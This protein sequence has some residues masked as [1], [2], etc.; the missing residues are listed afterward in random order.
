MADGDFSVYA[1][2]QAD[3]ANFEKGMKNAQTSANNLS[4]TFKNLQGIITKALSF[5]GVA[6]GTKAIIDFG[7]SAV[8][9]GNQA[10][11]Q[12][13][14]LD[15]TVKMT[16]ADAWTTTEDLEKMAKEL[17]ATTNY[18][19][20]EV[21]KMQSVLLGFTNITEGAFE[22]ASNA[23]LDMATVMGMDLTSAVQTV[24][25]ALDDPVTGLDSLRRQGFKFTDEQK[26]ELAQLVQNGKQL[27]AQKIILDTLA[28]SYGGASKAGQ[29]SFA[30]QRHAIENLKDTLGT[31]LIPIVKEFSENNVVMLN[32]LTSL[33]EKTDFTRIFA[34]VKA[35]ASTIKPIFENIS[36]YFKELGEGIKS[37]FSVDSL[38]PFISVIDTILGVLK[39]LFAEIKSNFDNVRELFGSMREGLG[40]LANSG[41]L[42]NITE[43]INK[44]IDV[45]FFL[46]EQ[47]KIVIDDL[48]S[49]I[50]DRVKIIWET[51]KQL[52]NNSNKALQE[53][54][55]GFSSWAEFFYSQ[56]DQV[57]RVAQDLI[58]GV[59][60]ILHGNWS[61]AWEYAKLAVMRACKFILDYVS[62]IANAFPSMIN[63]MLE[64]TNWLISELNKFRS[65]LGQKPID[66]LGVF[67]SVDLTES[68]GLG[69][70]IEDTEKKIEELTGKVAD[71]PIKSLKGIS[72][73]SA[74][75]TKDIVDNINNLT[76]TYI[77][78]SK[79]QHATATYTANSIS[80]EMELTYEKYSDWDSKLLN[81]RKGNLKEWQKEYHDI[82]IALIAQERKKAL[83]SEKNE[84]ERLKINEYYNKELENENKRYHKAILAQS[85]KV[86]KKI[87]DVWSGLTQIIGKVFSS[88]L[89]IAQ[90]FLSSL[91]GIFDLNI[92]ESIEKLLE[93]EDKI[94]TFF[95]ETLPKLP[96]F[97][98]SALQSIQ[99]LFQNLENSIDGSLI[100]NII[101]GMVDSLVST[102]PK[103]LTSIGN[104]ISE[105]I[106]GIL[107][108]VK[109]SLPSLKEL[110]GKIGNIFAGFAEK[111]KEQAP[112]FKE[113]ISGIADLL[114]NFISGIVD[115]G[116]IDDLADIAGDIVNAL[117][118]GLDKM[119][120]AISK[121]LGAI[122]PALG[123]FIRETTPNIIK[124][125]FDLVGVIAEN[126]PKIIDELI[127]S[128]PALITSI[129]ESLPKFF[130]EGL[131]ELIAGFIQ[132]IP[133]IIKAGVQIT[134]ELI[135]H[136]PEIIGSFIKGLV[137]GFAQV[138]WWE[139]VKSI[140]QAFIDGFKK[141]FGI[142]SPSTVFEGFGKNIFQ[143]LK[144]GL[145]GVGEWFI[146]IFTKAIDGIKNA[147]SKLK[148]WFSNL[149]DK[150]TGKNSSVAEVGIT[151]KEFA[152]K[153]LT[154]SEKA[155]AHLI[156]TGSYATG[157]QSVK[158]GLAFVGE[159]GPELVNFKGG[160]QVLNNRNTQNALKGASNKSNIFNV[161]FNNTMDTTAYAMMTQL[162]QYQRNLAFNGVL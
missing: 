51:I 113:V 48:K 70:A 155:K 31:K 101:K 134:V 143:G 158:R 20:T 12:F 54:E 5:A 145:K 23:V 93:F 128:L 133:D 116:L 80:S 126:L 98:Q 141:L 49:L 129:L 36:D 150:I 27:E 35:I 44:I 79:K 139:V 46:R 107:E 13:K 117:V 102:L 90:K 78:N 130:D 157:S 131:P 22:D 95:I 64:G 32:N 89:K 65:W 138:N 18:S 148:N 30:K 161:T 137:L 62:Q 156:A 118:D 115:S 104:V 88:I 149:W 57:F 132:I 135:K 17:S 112:L 76:E 142:N 84:K 29:D 15:N 24:G 108:G 2:I 26:A 73:A 105:I 9:S 122:I 75:T 16:G 77:S 146:G 66:L 38:K 7:K 124:M 47:I 14:I 21:E 40:G 151:E 87:G 67:E 136:L 140:F 111:I 154:A 94:L 103:I 3:T 74:G 45:I 60:A 10:V 109:S 4:N 159:A 85:L 43:I 11:K 68:S 106:G 119:L 72:K 52:F 61:V 42:Q 144:N 152:E 82:N 59:S 99:V 19:V 147:F 37:A 39:S 97:I 91:S 121:A 86:V 162:K 41:A 58:N 71:I 125:I 110:T 153:V 123:D 81:Q 1:K 56:F 100:S 96:A 50:F 28:T 25:K 92:D 63:K 6:V 83:E 127:K 34:T 114:S 55:K 53:N 33:I 120:P 69:K 8:Q 160:E